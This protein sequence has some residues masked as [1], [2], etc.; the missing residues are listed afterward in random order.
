MKKNYFDKSHPY[1]NQVEALMRETFCVG[2]LETDEIRFIW[3]MILFIGLQIIMFPF[4][5][6]MSFSKVLYLTI[7][8]IAVNF[9][10]IDL[11]NFELMVGILGFMFIFHKEITEFLNNISSALLIICSLGLLAH[12]VAKGYLLNKPFRQSIIEN[13]QNVNIITSMTGLFDR[14]YIR[15]YDQIQE[16]YMNSNNEEGEIKL[17]EFMSELHD[18]NL[19]KIPYLTR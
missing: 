12:W 4:M 3:G 6:L 19:E 10:G 5:L 11:K 8:I 18:E 15:K 17:K 2:V 13:E 14:K 16:L 7:L 1:F 9:F